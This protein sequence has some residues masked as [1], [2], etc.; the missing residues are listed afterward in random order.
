[1]LTVAGFGS[2][3]GGEK[4]F[5]IKCR[6]SGLKPTCA[7]LVCTVRALKLHSG[8]AP[9]V[10]AG[11]ALSTEYTE[12]NLPLVEAGT[13]NLLAHIHVEKPSTWLGLG[14]AGRGLSPLVFDTG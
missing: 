5:N 11:A 8:L 3:M 1:M 10:V 2:D 4:F 9:K 13:V 12:E 6:A 7:V 14:S